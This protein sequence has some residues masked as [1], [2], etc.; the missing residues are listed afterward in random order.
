MMNLLKALALCLEEVK[1]PHGN[2]LMIVG[3]ACRNVHHGKP[4]NDLDVAIL[5]PAID[6]IVVGTA[7]AQ[8][9]FSP[10]PV[11]QT[12]NPKYPVPDLGFEYNIQAKFMGYDVDF[13][14]RREAGNLGILFS[15]FDLTLN[16]IAF[17]HDQFIG[18]GAFLVPGDEIEHGP[19]Y[20][21]RHFDS[22]RQRLDRFAV[23]FPAYDWSRVDR[24]A[25][26]AKEEYDEANRQQ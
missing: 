8:A 9:G 14:R 3:G 17:R 2:S 10:D 11:V 26:K 4:I 22:H 23:E 15:G 20:T 19:L 5:G 18:R 21:A 6:S 16:M 13:L 25:K 1:L 12:A 24:E 7:L